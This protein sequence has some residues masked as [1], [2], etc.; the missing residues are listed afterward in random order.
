MGTFTPTDE[1]ARIMDVLPTGA[2]VKVIA[3]A[4]AGKTRTLDEASR[5]MDGRG[6]FTAF[7][8]DIVQDAASRFPAHVKCLTTHKL[9]HTA[10]SG[11]YGRRLR[12]SRSRQPSRVLAKMLGITETISFPMDGVEV[13]PWVIARLANAAVERFCT[14]AREEVSERD[15]PWQAGLNPSQ[16]TEVARVVLRYARILWEDIQLAD[17]QGS[18]RFNI[19]VNHLLKLFALR[20]PH[21]PF[22]FILLDEAQDTNPV[23]ADMFTRQSHAQLIAVGDPAQAINEWRGAVDAL[24]H[25]PADIT[26]TLSQ[27]FRFGPDIATE[28][29]KWLEL[30]GTDL[31]IIGAGGPSQV[32]ACTDPDAVLCRTNGAAAQEVLDAL[33]AGRRVALTGKTGETITRLAQACQE[34]Q[35]G[36]ATSH[37]ELTLFRTWDQVKDYVDEEDGSGGDLAAFVRMIDKHGA[38]VVLSAM[39]SLSPPETAD[40]VVSTMHKAKGLQWNRVRIGDFREPMDKSGKPLPIPPAELRLAYVAVTRARTVLDRG[41]LAWVDTR[42]DAAKEQA[43]RPARRTLTPN[44]LPLPARRTPVL[45]RHA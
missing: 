26:L 36:K 25:W 34:L 1:Q 45:A 2:N 33:A 14:S 4:G 27:S 17:D 39:D 42:L 28:A 11:L 37:P 5:L 23:V 13:R 18:G 38:N 20:R 30:L 35:A 6:L 29:N 22:D 15:V 44:A 8:R 43:T 9:A 3:G 16:R 19:T 40:T 10:M 24:E 32:T 21:L 12:R 41:A 31:R 7:N